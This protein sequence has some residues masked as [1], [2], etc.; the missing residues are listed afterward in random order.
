[1]IKAL[2]LIFLNFMNLIGEK[3]DGAF[4][5]VMKRAGYDGRPPFFIELVQEIDAIR[6][7]DDPFVKPLKRDRIVYLK[8]SGE[9]RGG[10]FIGGYEAIVNWRFLHGFWIGQRNN[11]I[12]YCFLYIVI[13]DGRISGGIAAVGHRHNH[14]GNEIRTVR[15]VNDTYLEISD[16]D[17]QVSSSLLLPHF[18][19]DVHSGLSGSVGLARQEEGE[20]KQNRANTDK[21]CG[22]QRI[23][24]HVAGGRLDRLCGGVH[25]LLGGKVFY[26][27]LAGFFFLA[28]TGLGLGF[29]FDYV[30]RDRARKQ[31]GWII[32]STCLPLGVA[33]LLLGLP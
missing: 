2:A 5:P 25:S 14:S 24:P 15:V 26:L 21:D 30:N 22:I 33:C 23:V 16:L 31:V 29:I 7:P 13:D 9:A 27:P 18:T 3:G 32:L 20:K 17:I 1:M 4:G 28:L 10:V 8:S 11:L 12:G 19:G 6:E